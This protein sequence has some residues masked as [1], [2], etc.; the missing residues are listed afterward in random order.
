MNGVEVKAKLEQLIKIDTKLE[1]NIKTYTNCATL[2]Q[3][4]NSF[5]LNEIAIT[6]LEYIKNQ[7]KIE[8]L[9]ILSGD[10]SERKLQ[11]F[12]K[13]YNKTEA[14]LKEIKEC[15]TRCD[16]LMQQISSDKDSSVIKPFQDDISQVNKNSYSIKQLKEG[17]NNIEERLSLIALKPNLDKCEALIVK[18]GAIELNGQVLFPSDYLKKLQQDEMIGAISID[19]KRHRV[20]RFEQNLKEIDLNLTKGKSAHDMSTELIKSLSDLKFDAQ[21]IAPIKALQEEIKNAL[22]DPDSVD[23]LGKT[24]DNC[25]MK[26]NEHQDLLQQFKQNYAHCIIQ[27]EELRAITVFSNDVVA[28]EERQEALSNS[29]MGVA[30]LK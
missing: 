19:V 7:Q 1:Q 8:L 3:E 11:F 24:L 18:I 25:E 16:G 12:E 28:L 15:Y 2:I 13:K 4:I 6:S 29:I 23:D 17:L 9:N 20:S 26:L 21:V 14:E 27:M 5:K 22:I 30:S 10:N